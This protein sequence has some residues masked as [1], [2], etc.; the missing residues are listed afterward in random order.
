MLY[1]CHNRLLQASAGSRLVSLRL[2]HMLANLVPALVQRL[3]KLHSFRLAGKMPNSNRPV[4][5]SGVDRT[6]TEHRERAVLSHDTSSLNSI[7]ATRV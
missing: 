5:A 1:L 7:V 6:S 4:V 3:A 2:A